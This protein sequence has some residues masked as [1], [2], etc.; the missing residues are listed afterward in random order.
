[1]PEKRLIISL[2]L[3]LLVVFAATFFAFKGF[4][5]IKSIIK[6]PR[7]EVPQDVFSSAVSCSFIRCVESRARAIPITDDEGIFRCKDFAKLGFAREGKICDNKEFID[8]SQ[9]P[10]EIKID[11]EVLYEDGERIVYN[12]D[13][14]PIF[15]HCISPR[16]EISV[17]RLG[18]GLIR[19]LRFENEKIDGG[20]KPTIADGTIERC[21]SE[22]LVGFYS[23]DK[24][25]SKFQLVDELDGKKLYIYTK[26]RG[27]YDDIVEVVVT[28]KKTYKTFKEG[29]WDELIVKKKHGIRYRINIDTTISGKDDKDYVLEYDDNRKKIIMWYIDDPENKQDN[30]IEFGLTYYFSFVE[31]QRTIELFLQEEFYDA[32]SFG[33]C[34]RTFDME[35]PT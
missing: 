32:Y 14:F 1:M 19:F 4:P 26:I 24:S 22:W 34:P 6:I 16:D 33:I 5:L 9:F 27:W 23:P 7:L 18:G 30:P 3:T 20:F 21:S 28:D 2:I 17:N 25:F 13:T 15:F 31:N 11:Q 12:R 29:E 35:C 10:V 8:S